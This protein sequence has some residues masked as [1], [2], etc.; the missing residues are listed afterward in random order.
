MPPAEPIPE[1]RENHQINTYTLIYI[2]YI[3]VYEGK[4][5]RIRDREEGGAIWV[6]KVRE[7]YSKKVTLEQSPEGVKE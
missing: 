2:K 7:G 1:E 6:K 4:Q 3:D 5:S